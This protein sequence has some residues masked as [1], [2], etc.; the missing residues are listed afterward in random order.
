H[1]EFFSRRRNFRQR[2][3]TIYDT[4]RRLRSQKR[5]HANHLREVI[6]PAPTARTSRVP[7][8]FSA[9]APEGGANVWH[10]RLA[11]PLAREGFW[12]AGFCEEFFFESSQPSL[13]ARTP[14]SPQESRKSPRNSGW[15]ESHE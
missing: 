11:G 5:R 12:R 7:D 8:L 13:L 2:L 10:P 9:G 3:C 6:A 1:A 14:S 15:G 4:A